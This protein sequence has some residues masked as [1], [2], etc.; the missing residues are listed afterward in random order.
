MEP[1][2]RFF[3][4]DGKR[5][6][7]FSFFMALMVGG[8]LQDML[9][10]G[11][12]LGIPQPVSG[13]LSLISFWRIYNF[14]SYPQ[15]IFMVFLTGLSGPGADVVL[16]ATDPLVIVMD[17]AYLY[18]LACAVGYSVETAR[19]KLD[20]LKEIIRP[21]KAKTLIFIVLVF[22]GLSSWS[23]FIQDYIGPY[24]AYTFAEVEEP[25]N[26][27]LPQDE[28]GNELSAGT[29]FGS[30][31]QGMMFM[32]LL[33][34]RFIYSL[35][36]AAA[37]LLTFN[38]TGILLSLRLVLVLIELSYLYFVSGLIVY[39]WRLRRNRAVWA[40]AASALAVIVLVPAALNYSYEKTG[41]AAIDD[42]LNACWELEY[43]QRDGCYARVAESFGE[44]GACQAI[45]DVSLRETC[46]QHVCDN[47][48]DEISR[49][50][51]RQRVEMF[52][53]YQERDAPSDS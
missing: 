20:V 19:S 5:L 11:S 38:N 10:S 3:W 21:V 25:G 50:R 28:P 13:V 22:L 48:P 27:E 14:L 45:E 1:I 43:D 44:I 7:L 33:P 15:Y 4:P 18:T 12:N 17:I 53:L 46:Y 8:I 41:S 47:R 34:A 2:K 36:L 32:L 29:S 23:L 26:T 16:A 40:V 6:L 39:A 51:C 37:T 30:Q 31:L 42:E 35:F 49:E 9:L 52:R 24:I